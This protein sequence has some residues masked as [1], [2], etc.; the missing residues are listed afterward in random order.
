MNVD[1]F[2]EIAKLVISVIVTMNTFSKLEKNTKLSDDYF[3]K[4]LRIYAK[5]YKNNPKIES[6]NFIKQKFD[7]SNYFVPSYVF[8]L[9]DKG[10][11]EKLHKILINDYIQK[12]PSKENSIFN[13]IYDIVILFL[14]VL[15]F[16]YCLLTIVFSIIGGFSFSSLVFDIVSSKNIDIKNIRLI[17]SSISMCA[18]LIIFIRLEKK[19]ILDEYTMKVGNIKEIIKRKE[20]NFNRL[21]K[22]GKYY[23]T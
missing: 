14:S 16:V 23:I 19:C 15:V 10:E 6:L 11:S 2:T 13:G 22:N 18:I 17:R 3:E 9:V 20:R 4:V 5:E 21:N 12:L 8:Y 1:K 7:I